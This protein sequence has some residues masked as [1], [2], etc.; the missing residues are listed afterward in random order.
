MKN[1]IFEESDFSDIHEDFELNRDQKAIVAGIAQAKHDAWFKELIES[2]PV[3]SGFQES[4][5]KSWIMDSRPNSGSTHKARL[6]FIEEIEKKPC[7]HEPL[8]LVGLPQRN[9]IDKS[10]WTEPVAY[11]CKQCLAMI[12]PTGWVAK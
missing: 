3:V 8:T 11:Q 1:L 5:Y 9:F 2:W 10:I 4:E 12:E 6:A 7:E